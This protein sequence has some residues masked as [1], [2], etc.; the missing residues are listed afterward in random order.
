MAAP[1]FNPFGGGASDPFGATSAPNPFD[2]PAQSMMPFGQMG[3]QPNKSH[4]LIADAFNDLLVTKQPSPEKPKGGNIDLGL[5]FGSKPKQNEQ[6]II[7]IQP[8]QVLPTQTA[9][10]FNNFNAAPADDDF[11]E[12]GDFET[13]AKQEDDGFG[14]FGTFEAAPVS[15][16]KATDD[17]FGDFGAF[18]EVKS[19]ATAKVAEDPFASMFS[20]TAS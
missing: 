14:E 2:A 5:N 12:F 15:A 4:D 18:A 8:L 6:K 3:Q 13:A 10:T 1:E 19:V 16:P 17:G 11:G 7:P 9:P 20:A